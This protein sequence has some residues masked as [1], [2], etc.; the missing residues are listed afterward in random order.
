[1]ST[2]IT[3]H[4]RTVATGA[5]AAAIALSA[6]CGGNGDTTS[7]GTNRG[8]STA[9]STSKPA[10][11]SKYPGTADGAKAL[12]AEFV[13]PGADLPALSKQLEPSKADYEAVFEPSLSSKAETMYEPAWSSGQMVVQPKA[14]QTE[15]KLISA[16]TDELKSWSGK[17]E[18]FPGGYKDVASHF[19]PGLTLYKFSFVEP[20]QDLG[21]A[22]DGLVYVN[23]N[24]RL[25]PK[26]YRLVA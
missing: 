9:P 2:R 1:M 24:W 14:G 22:F 23:G 16:T 19:K 10:E 20:G 7:G 6:A 25:F 5:L 11:S 12:L 17:A 26:P 4:W 18:D 15:V 3:I 8:G 13:K 21:M